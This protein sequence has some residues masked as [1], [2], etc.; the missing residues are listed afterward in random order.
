MSIQNI[1]KRFAKN[2]APFSL[3]MSFLRFPA[4]TAEPHFKFANICT[5]IATP[6]KTPDSRGVA[7]QFLIDKCGLTPE[8]IAKAFRHTN[9]LLRAKSSQNMEKVVEL[10]NGCG[11]TSPA[12]IRRLVLYNPSFLFRRAERNI[13]SKLNLLR[14]FMK[15]EH[16]SKLLSTNARIFNLGEQKLRSS[17][18]LLQKLGVEGEALSDILAWVP[19][20]LTASEEK[21]M[22][23]FKQ[24]EDIGFK[25]GSKMF[26]I[27]LRAYFGLAKEKL[28]RKRQYLS[29][30]GFSE[31]QILYLVRRRPM[32]L[33]LSEEKL[34]RNVDFLV[35]TVRLELTDIVKF[36]DLFANSLE[37]RMIPR[38]IVLEAMKFKQLQVSKRERCFPVIIQLTEKRFLEEYVNSNAKFSSVLQDIY[39][40]GK[41]GKLVLG[42]ETLCEFF[43]VEKIKESCHSSSEASI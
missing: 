32:V 5:Q 34:K 38:Y 24:V 25:K 29:S 23:V 22:E 43:S 37:R 28:D 39:R 11:L 41:A 4:F 35:K 33:A 9:T 15:E 27:A 21:V 30:L 16:L 19:H 26:R 1:C 31:Q 17:I 12:Q 18:S 14:T 20:L 7:T 10:L 36:P 2:D 3:A 40:K 42:K 13:Q 6:S 8:E